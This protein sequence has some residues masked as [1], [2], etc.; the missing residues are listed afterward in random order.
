MEK[1]GFR[2]TGKALMATIRKTITLTTQQNQW[3]RAQI[4]HGRYASDSEYIRD[5]VRRDQEFEARRRELKDA[6]REGLESGVYEG[7]ALADVRENL[8]RA[9]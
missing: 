9:E 7:D 3:V 4:D 8:G 2:V 5:L 1:R 6:I